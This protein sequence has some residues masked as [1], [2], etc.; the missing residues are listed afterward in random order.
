MLRALCWLSLLIRKS[1]ADLVVPGVSVVVLGVSLSICP[2][3]GVWDEMVS[4]GA[5]G[6]IVSKNSLE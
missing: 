1:R 4:G 3:L 6:P 5:R 2:S